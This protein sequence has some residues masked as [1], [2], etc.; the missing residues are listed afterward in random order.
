MQA[1]PNPYIASGYSQLPSGYNVHEG[2]PSAATC[3]KVA[4]LNFSDCR[5][6]QQQERRTGQRE[7]LSLKG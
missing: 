3:P 6:W 5:S 4:V 1:Q 2:N 7:G